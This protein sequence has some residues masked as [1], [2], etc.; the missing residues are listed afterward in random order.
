LDTDE[1]IAKALFDL[2]IWAV[3]NLTKAFI[4]LLKTAHGTVINIS[5]VVTKVNIPFM[6]IY[7]ASKAAL[8]S[9][10]DAMRL[11]LGAL[12]ISTIIVTAGGVQTKIFDNTE[13]FKIP[14][15]SY[16]FNHKEEIEA[17]KNKTPPESMNATVF[18]KDVAN[19]VMKRKKPA[20]IWAGEKAGLVWFL[21][22]FFP[23][24]ITD[25]ISLKATG[26]AP[27]LSYPGNQKKGD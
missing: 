15:G 20:R 5:S 9:I 23:V 21:T 24:S 19:K 3:I 10:S 14:E 11:E 17:L 6:G 22:A 13:R 8:D 25:W 27:Y 26:L 18:A 12:D 2:H 7:S 1:S 4:P 16:Y